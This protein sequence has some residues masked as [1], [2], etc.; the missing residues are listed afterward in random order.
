MIRVEIL[1][2]KMTAA[3]IRAAPHPAACM[4]SKGEF[5][6]YSVIRTGMLAVGWEK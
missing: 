3:I 1:I 6:E 4:D 5:I 2:I